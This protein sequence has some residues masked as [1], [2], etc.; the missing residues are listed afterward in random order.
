P[1]AWLR[2]EKIRTPAVSA[3]E[4][5]HGGV[6]LG[7]CPLEGFARCHPPRE[8]ELWLARLEL[9][10]RA[11]DLEKEMRWADLGHGSGNIA[12]RSQEIADALALGVLE[13]R[14][15]VRAA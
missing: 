9:L 8:R 13:R 11:R 3:A 12:F 5:L 4:K 7:E 10:E 15:G 6:T 1:L 2:H 14:T